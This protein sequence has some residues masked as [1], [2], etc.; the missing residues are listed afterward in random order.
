MTEHVEEELAPFHLGQLPAA[1]RA[2]VETHVAGCGSCGARSALL[3]RAVAKPPPSKGAFP[4]AALDARAA[5][6]FAPLLAKLF[7][8][9]AEAARGVLQQVG[10]EGAWVPAEPDGVHVLPVASGPK[11]EGAFTALARVQP[12]AAF[13]HHRHTGREEVVVLQGGYVDSEGGEW[14]QGDVDVHEAGTAHAFVA[15]KGVACITAAVLFGEP[16]FS[17]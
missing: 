13:P 16:P 8:I 2:E 12:L 15:R 17:G 5:E 11:C 1:R 3:Q 10:D 4:A 14:W 9:S 6:R 7:D